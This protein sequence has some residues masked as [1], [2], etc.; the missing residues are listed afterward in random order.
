MLVKDNVGYNGVINLCVVRLN[1][2]THDWE[3][4]I[5]NKLSQK[6]IPVI[7]FVAAKVMASNPSWLMVS[8]IFSP[9]F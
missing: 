6:I 9:L 5:I 7:K 2:G 3:R 4:Q 1:V 8:A